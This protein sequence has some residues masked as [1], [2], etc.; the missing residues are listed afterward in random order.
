MTNGGGALQIPK[1]IR[2]P[3][4]RPH[5]LPQPQQHERVPVPRRPLPPFRQSR[6]VRLVLD[7]YVSCGE[8]FLEY[9]RQA[10]V[11]AGE[12]VGVAEVPGGRLDQARRPDAHRVER[13]GAR[14]LRGPLDQRHRLIEGE[15]RREIPGDRD[16][17]LREHP[18]HQVGDD[19]GDPVGTHIERGQR[20]PAR[21]NPVQLRVGPP[22]MRPGL[23]D[24]LDQPRSREAFREV[25][26]RRPGE[27]R[28]L[29]QL[30]RRQRTFAL[31]QAQGEPVV[32]GS[33]RAR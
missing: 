4:R 24:D 6:E 27:P 23:T 20:S 17:S 19:D 13:V 11:P 32:D 26:D 16:G 3:D 22:P 1:V 14:L 31:E 21:D 2:V 12:A 10:P 5:P 9:R 29:L 33:G 30:P 7:E 25:R 28:E 15:V 18:P 8:T